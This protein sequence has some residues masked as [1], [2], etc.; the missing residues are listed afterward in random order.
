MNKSDAKLTYQNKLQELKSL[1]IPHPNNKGRVFV[2]V[3]G[4]TDIKLF[5]KFFEPDS[6]RVEA[7]P[8]GNLKVEEATEELLKIS[9]LVIGIRDADFIRLNNRLNNIN[10]NKTNVFLTDFHDIEMSLIVNDDSFSSVIVEYTEQNLKECNYEKIREN[11]LGVLENVGFLKWLND[12]EKLE[13][14]F[15]GTGFEDLIDFENYKL[16]FKQYF[17]RLLSKST[18]VKIKDICIILEKIKDL[19]LLSPCLLQL[20]NGHDFIKIMLLFLNNKDIKNQISKENMSSSFRVAYTRD[21]FKKTQLY[22]SV[23]SWSK[24]NNCNI[25]V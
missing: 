20:C 9:K 21:M 10:Y 2:L 6:T 19:K 23:N 14:K 8:G 12:V 5:N 16:D 25:F 17:N 7:I 15:E 4:E 3:E 1:V 11:I 24:V 13:I 22:S 18:N